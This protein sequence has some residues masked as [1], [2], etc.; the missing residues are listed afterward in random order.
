MYF[1]YLLAI[2]FYLCKELREVKYR[3][4]KA[5]RTN[6]ND[7]LHPIG[8]AKLYYIGVS[9]YREITRMQQSTIQNRNLPA[10]FGVRIWFNEPLQI[11]EF[12]CF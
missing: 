5:Q 8:V 9:C 4:I 3:M 2:I 10:I 6:E 1:I 12:D 11:R 7:F